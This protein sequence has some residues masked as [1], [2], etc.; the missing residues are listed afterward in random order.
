NSFDNFSFTIPPLNEQKEIA[1]FLDKK[2]E[3]NR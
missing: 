1:E 3:K 2:C